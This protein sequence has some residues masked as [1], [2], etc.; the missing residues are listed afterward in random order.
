MGVGDGK[1]KSRVGRACGGKEIDSR[2]QPT[3]AELEM[4]LS[5]PDGITPEE[6]VRA[7]F[8]GDPP[9]VEEDKGKPSKEK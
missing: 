3:K 4:D 5:L 7:M 8:S 9:R 6:V 1:K 2:Y